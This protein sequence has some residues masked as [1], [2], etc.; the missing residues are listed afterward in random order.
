MKEGGNKSIFYV[1]VDNARAN[2]LAITYRNRGKSV[3]KGLTLFNGEY[4]HLRCSAH[5]LNLIV[6]EGLK[7][8]KIR[9]SCKFVKSSPSRL[10]TFK[11]CAEAMNVCSKAMITL[12][13]G[14]VMMLS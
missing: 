10:A 3:W 14:I 8:S 9:A 5:I 7:E 6:T 2:N 11:K 1:T 4:L 12:D 13:V